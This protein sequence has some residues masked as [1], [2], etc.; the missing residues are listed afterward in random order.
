MKHR[1][2]HALNVG[3]NSFLFAV[4]S[5]GIAIPQTQPSA[6]PHF[7]AASIKPSSSAD[8][9]LFYNMS[10]IQAGGQFTVSNITVKR[11][12]QDAY[13]IKAFQISGGPGWIGS[14]LFDIAAKPYG[15]V[16]PAQF[17]NMLQSLLAERFQL[18]IKSDTKETP[19]YALVVAKNGPKFKAA[20]ESDPNIIDLTGRPVPQGVGRPRITIIRRGR[21][22]T[23]GTDMASLANNLADFLGRTVLDKTGFM[24]MYD[25]KLE[26]RPDEN[27]VAMFGAMGLP[28]GFG[29]PPPDWDGPSLFTALEEQLGLKL[30]SQKDPSIFSRSSTSKDRQRTNSPGARLPCSGWTG[31]PLRWLLVTPFTA[32]RE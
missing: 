13:R 5:C 6:A 18:A 32:N 30:D 3:R 1:L 11:L 29:A 25:L 16:S 21:L 8:H 14:E 15:P 20:H 4:A 26:W 28:E 31:I 9:R 2:A 7:E 12:I 19:V 23:Q 10:N 22:M 27:Q 24:G 17:Q